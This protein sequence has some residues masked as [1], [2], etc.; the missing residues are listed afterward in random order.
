MMSADAAP[1]GTKALQIPPS[2]LRRRVEVIRGD[3]D[4][5]ARVGQAQTLRFVDKEPPAHV[6]QRIYDGFPSA[7]DEA[8][9]EQF[10]QADWSERSAL[11]VQIKDLR[12]REFARRLMYFERPEVLPDEQS[13]ELSTWMAN[14]VLTEDESVPW[15]TVRKALRE[16]DV[17]LRNA[18]GEEA[19]LLS[20]V[21]EFL[22]SRAEESSAAG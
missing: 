22:Y 17:L 3:P 5:Q 15:M 11:A 4:F 9:M 14:R 8:L 1:N 18:R 7:A 2:E 12:L 19:G 6:E 16:T 13:A 10:H 20:E 21:R